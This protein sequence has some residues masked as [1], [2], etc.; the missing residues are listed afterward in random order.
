MGSPIWS[1]IGRRRLDGSCCG[2]RSW[3]VVIEALGVRL[4][5]GGEGEDD[6]GV[7]AGTGVLAGMGVL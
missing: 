7:D 6:R 4:G 1:T 2:G 3:I 5:R